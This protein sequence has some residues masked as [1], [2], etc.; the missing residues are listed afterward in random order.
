VGT[1][2]GE[3]I[4]FFHIPMRVFSCH[5]TLSCCHTVLARLGMFTLN[6]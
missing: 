1:Y 4:Y 6:I 5:F 3:P 2:L